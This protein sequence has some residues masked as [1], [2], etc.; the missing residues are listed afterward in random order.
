MN[1]FRYCVLLIYAGL[2]APLLRPI[3]PPSDLIDPN[4]RALQMHLKNP[5]PVLRFVKMD[6]AR[7]EESPISLTRFGDLSNSVDS[8]QLSC[9]FSSLYGSLYTDM[10][11]LLES[12]LDS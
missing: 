11:V 10:D 12:N 5:T 7:V 4:I 3:V 2:Y 6:P 8:I 9:R 1:F